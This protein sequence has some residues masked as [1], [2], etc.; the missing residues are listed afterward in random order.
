MADQERQTP[1]SFRPTAEN[2]AMINQLRAEQL[3]SGA[4][5]TDTTYIINEAIKLFYNERNNKK[6]E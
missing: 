5:R 4:K 1:I 6:D 2:I 3:I